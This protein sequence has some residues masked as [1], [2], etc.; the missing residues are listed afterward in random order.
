MKKDRQEQ[1]RLTGKREVLFQQAVRECCIGFGEHSNKLIMRIANSVFPEFMRKFFQCKDDNDFLYFNKDIIEELVKK[2][3]KRN[4]KHF[5]YREWANR[6]ESIQRCRNAVPHDFVLINSNH[7][8]VKHKK[9]KLRM[10][11]TFGLTMAV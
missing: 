3:M 10:L 2:S 6:R 11:E 5:K 4:L 9:I 7:K 8:Y 1:K